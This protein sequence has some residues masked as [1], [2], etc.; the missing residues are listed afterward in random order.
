M[1]ITA[2]LLG[3]CLGFAS[4]FRFVAIGH[5]RSKWRISPL[6]YD[7]GIGGGCNS[8]ESPSKINMLPVK[9]QQSAVWK[10]CAAMAV[11]TVALLS[12]FHSLEQASEYFRLWQLSWPLLGPIFMLAGYTHFTL[13]NDYENIYPQA[14][15]WGLWNVPFS[16]EFHVLWTGLAEI[17]GGGALVCGAL[18]SYV[19]QGHN[20]TLLHQA[21][22]ILFLLTIIVT[23]ANIFMWTHGARLPMSQPSPPVVF[24]YVRF[25]FQSLL[26][27]MFASM[28]L[29]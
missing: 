12:L 14:D 9:E 7:Q 21:A 22:T 27:A 18:I 3:L 2:L 23:P 13:K 4:G 5:H 29:N 15:A 24:H 16:A 10:A 25:F 26:L 19:T 1:K 17:F 6:A 28:A 11:G 8:I 20:A